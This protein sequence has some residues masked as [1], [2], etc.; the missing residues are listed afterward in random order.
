MYSIKPEKP[1]YV[2]GFNTFVKPFQEDKQFSPVEKRKKEKINI[3]RRKMRKCLEADRA[4][5]NRIC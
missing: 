1:Y 4:F 3:V 5:R 2:R